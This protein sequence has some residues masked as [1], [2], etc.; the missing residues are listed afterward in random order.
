M[1]AKPAAA[2]GQDQQVKRDSI[3]GGKPGVLGNLFNTWVALHTYQHMVT[4][5]G[6]AMLKDVETIAGSDMW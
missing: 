5:D 6:V 2:E 4:D 1:S 3:S